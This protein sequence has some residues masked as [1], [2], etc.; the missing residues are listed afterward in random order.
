MTRQ[1]IEEQKANFSLMLFNT[2]INR[3]VSM[4][5]ME[6][7]TPSKLATVFSVNADPMVLCYVCLGSCTILVEA[8]IGLIRHTYSLELR[9]IC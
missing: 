7:H 5:A 8:S 1:H 6:T 9:N 3:P 4:I 2:E